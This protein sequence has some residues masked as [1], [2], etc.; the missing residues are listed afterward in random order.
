MGSDVSNCIKVFP[1][2]KYTADWEDRAHPSSAT[3]KGHHSL[4]K[5]TFTSSF[6]LSKCYNPR[7]LFL[8]DFE[9]KSII[10]TTKSIS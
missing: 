7:A 2:P 6:R 4:S 1:Q 5:N 8:M 10:K 3:L 9:N